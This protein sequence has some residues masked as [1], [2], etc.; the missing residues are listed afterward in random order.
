[1]SDTFRNENDPIV[2][3]REGHVPPEAV[4]GAHDADGT[5]GRVA[6]TGSGLI[7][8]AI[9]GTAMGGPVGTVIGAVAGA[10]LGGAAGNAA[11]HVGDDHDD[12]NIETG[13]GGDLGKNAGAGAG[14]LS[15]AI[16]GAAAAGP[17][18]AVAGAVAGGMLGAA[19]GNAA[20]DMGGDSDNPNVVPAG[21][22]DSNFT[23]APMGSS[24]P[25]T[26]IGSGIGSG[27]VTGAPGL[28]LG[29]GMSGSSVGSD[30]SDMGDTHGHNAV[31]G[32]EATSGAGKAG[33]GTGAIVGGLIGTA[34]GGPVG[35]VVGGTLGSLAGGVTGDAAEA[36]E[37]GSVSGLGL[38]G[39]GAGT[40]T[41]EM[42]GGALNAPP[43]NRS[44]DT[45]GLTEKAAD[46]L[47]G[48]H[49]DDKTG[50]RI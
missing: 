20:K 15:G 48:D 31:T 50:K 23:S 39:T 8:G 49:T 19:A 44:P 13:S 47:S 36:T 21:H 45:R 34:V 41:T 10:L 32:D 46:A 16:V 18:G 33:L 42:A 37:G 27:S 26:I 28:P 17:V 38:G 2:D 40:G 29:A 4:E 25:G 1:M 35:A 43:S 12:V 9:V 30:M 6:G 7:S 24:L 11:H 3:P 14:G 5:M 22:A